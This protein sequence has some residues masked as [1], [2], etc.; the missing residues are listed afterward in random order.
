MIAVAVDDVVAA[1][2]RQVREEPGRERV[3]LVRRARREAPHEHA[4]DA[5]ALGGG[6]GP[7]LREDLDL[8]AGRR[9]PRRDP[10]DVALDAT[11]MRRVVRADV[12]DL[13]PSRTGQRAA[14]HAAA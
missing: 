13:Q 1:V 11:E 7:L 9:H 4:T 12:R 5:L 8:G 14:A 10:L 6:A 2:R 3:G